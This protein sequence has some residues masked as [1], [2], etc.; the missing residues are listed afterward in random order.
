MRTEV[1]VLGFLVYDLC[2]DLNLD[3][4]RRKESSKHKQFISFIFDFLNFS[5]FINIHCIVSF[6]G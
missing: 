5:F 2:E 3:K 6:R 1:S 4:D